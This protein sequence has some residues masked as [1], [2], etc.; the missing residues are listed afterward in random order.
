M[1]EA[2]VLIIT[3]GHLSREICCWQYR[4]QVNFNQSDSLLKSFFNAI[5]L[6]D[7]GDHDSPHFSFF[8]AMTFQEIADHDS[9]QLPFLY[10]ITLQNLGDHSYV[11]SSFVLLSVNCHD[12]L[13]NIVERFPVAFS[14]LLNLELSC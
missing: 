5:T 14:T 11:Q 1:T 7:I 3:I 9:S 12:V 6:Y 8:N 10:T 13:G 4:L 2:Q